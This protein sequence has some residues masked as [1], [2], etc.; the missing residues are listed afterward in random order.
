ME[1][2]KPKMKRWNVD[3][4]LTQHF[5]INIDG[6]DAQVAIDSAKLEY[7]NGNIDMEKEVVDDE[8]FDIKAATPMEDQD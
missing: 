2:K 4:V 1:N 6:T 7:E 5:T 3:C 8:T